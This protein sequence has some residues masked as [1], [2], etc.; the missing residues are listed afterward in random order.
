[1]RPA[2]IR[3]KK[4]LWGRAGG[5]AQGRKEKEGAMGGIRAGGVVG[6]RYLDTLGSFLPH[7]FCS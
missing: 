5:H 7:Q 2:A 3:A 4:S 1:M 6:G